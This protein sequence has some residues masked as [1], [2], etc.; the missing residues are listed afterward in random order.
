MG[1][2]TKAAVDHD[3]CVGSGDCA[4]IAPGSFE[5]NDDGLAV[6][7]EGAHNADTRQLEQAARECPTGAVR[8]LGGR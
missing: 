7:I 5:V 6:V 4:L 1:G 2:R 8:V 3:L